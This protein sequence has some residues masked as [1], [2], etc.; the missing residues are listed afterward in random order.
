MNISNT[1]RFTYIRVEYN[2]FASATCTYSNILRTWYYSFCQLLR[3][4]ILEMQISRL[5]FMREKAG[6]PNTEILHFTVPET[7]TYAK[8]KL[9]KSHL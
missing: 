9:I 1:R 3:T 5:G 8:V 4:S 6:F 7:S 2:G